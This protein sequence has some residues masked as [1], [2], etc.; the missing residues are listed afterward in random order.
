MHLLRATEQETVSVSIE[1]FTVPLTELSSGNRVQVSFSTGL[2]V[3]LSLLLYLV[4]VIVMLLFA[5]ACSL[6]VPESDGVMF[7]A[8]ALGLVSGL[9]GSNL[10]VRSLEA[11]ARQSLVCSPIESLAG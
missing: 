5:I 1:H 2:L 11:N 7:F 4:P 6:A 3:G 8:A 9:L 10:L